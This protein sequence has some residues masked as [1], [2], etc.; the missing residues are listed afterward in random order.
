MTQ[1]Q[2]DH[3]T[4][5]WPYWDP[6]SGKQ[7]STQALALGLGS[8]FNHSRTQN[9]GFQRD[10]EKQTL[11]FSTLRDIAPQEELCISYGPRLWFRDAES[12]VDAASEEEPDIL[13]AI[14]LASEP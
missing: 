7:K 9:T 5:N 14:D 12:E 1:T 3:Y 6:E 10:V 2:I 8:M 13:A 11:T 4:F